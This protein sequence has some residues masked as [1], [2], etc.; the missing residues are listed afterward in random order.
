MEARFKIET[1]LV[2][3]YHDNVKLSGYNRIV[4]YF[5]TYILL[6]YYNV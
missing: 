5:H 1:N 3:T 4:K 6:Y 2:Q